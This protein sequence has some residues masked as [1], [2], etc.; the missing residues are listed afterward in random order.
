[1]GSYGKP[2]GSLWEAMGR[3][4]V[5]LTGSGAAWVAGTGNGG[6]MRG[7][8]LRKGLDM[9]RGDYMLWSAT[10]RRSLITAYRPSSSPARAA[11]GTTGY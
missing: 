2:M 6:A 8:P 9:D 4:L 3:S 5:R 11:R 7:R 10:E 1:M